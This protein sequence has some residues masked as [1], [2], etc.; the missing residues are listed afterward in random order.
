M[1]PEQ[2]QDEMDMIQPHTLELLQ[3][4]EINQQIATAKRY[5][6]PELAKIKKKMLS[7]ATLDEETAGSCFYTLRRSG[8]NSDESK[9][10]QGPSVRLAEIAVSC[11]G[12][13]RAASRVIDN[14]GRSVTAQ[15]VCH[16][17]ENNTLVSVEV[18]RRITNKKGQTYSD[19]MQIVT[20]N[21]ANS[22]AFR[23]AVF[24]VIPGAIINS[25]YEAA[26]HVAVGD[27]STLAAKREK[28]IKRFNSMGVDTPRILSAVSRVTIEAI[29][30]DDLE[31]LIGLGT[32]I[33][34]GDTTVEDAFPVKR[35]TIEDQQKVAQDKIDQLKANAPKKEETEQERNAR[36]HQQMEEQAKQ[37]QQTEHKQESTE[38]VFTP[39]DGELLTIADWKE[40]DDLKEMP[41]YV[42]LTEGI[43]AGYHIYTKDEAYQPL[44]FD[45]ISKSW[46]RKTSKAESET[47]TPPVQKLAF[48]KKGQ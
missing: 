35:G 43:D 34:G 42:H 48:G 7:F 47:K 32:A 28:I 46:K 26:K 4:A 40:L 44:V 25:V 21:A 33:K 38:P 9:V 31:T 37:V 27:V 18:K 19:D 45:P 17:L 8:G 1:T 24:K 13:L 15:G 29:D 3:N 10:I 16:D 20:G 12:N 30:L 23:N 6:R 22:I 14:D 11:Y 41:P 36:L 5:P 2:Q 39:E